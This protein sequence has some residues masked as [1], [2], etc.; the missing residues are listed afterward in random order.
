MKKFKKGDKKMEAQTENYKYLLGWCTDIY[1]H[2]ESL[3]PKFS[4]LFDLRT[5]EEWE[6][7]WRNLMSKLQKNLTVDSE[8]FETATS[9]YEQW[10]VLYKE[11]HP[12]LEGNESDEREN[13]DQDLK[14]ETLMAIKPFVDYG[15]KEVALTSYEHAL[16]EIAAMAYL[17]G[18]GFDQQTA[19]K[20]VESWEVNE[21]F[22]TEYGRFKMNKY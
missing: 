1:V 9:L 14:S 8:D 4:K 15:L 20:T 16:T 10:E 12:N 17:L 18:K 11:A 6:E 2:W 5:L 3:K 22:E 19:Y 21:M 7:T 13:S